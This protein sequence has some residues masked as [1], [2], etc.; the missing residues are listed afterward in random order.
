MADFSPEEVKFNPGPLNTA[1]QPMA[2]TPGAFGVQVGQAIQNVGETADRMHKTAVQQWNQVS[3]MDAYNKYEN[4]IQDKIFKSQ[5]GLIHQNFG[6]DA[7]GAVEK[8]Q[9]YLK[10]QSSKIN[11]NLYNEQ[12]KFMFQRMTQERNLQLQQHLN[13]YADRQ[14]NNY[15]AET[16]QA[17]TK[18]AAQNAVQA[19][20]GIASSTDPKYS[21]PNARAGAFNKAAKEQLDLGIAAIKD[22]FKHANPTAPDT[23]V[24][25]TEKIAAYQSA[26]TYG[27]ITSLG[28]QGKDLDAERYY[29]DHKSELVGEEAVHAARQVETGSRIGEA[30]TIINGLRQDDK[31]QERSNADIEKDILSNP[32]VQ[33]DPRLQEAVYRQFNM[34]ARRRDIIHTDEQNQYGNVLYNAITDPATRGDLNTIQAQHPHEWEMLDGKSKE[35]FIELSEKIQKNMLPKD[36]SPAF[37]NFMQ[38]AHS[39]EYIDSI[40]QTGSQAAM[41]ANPQELVNAGLITPSDAEKMYKEQDRI[42]GNQAAVAATT[43]TANDRAAVSPLLINA[44]LNPKEFTIKAGQK[45][46][47][48]SPS[49]TAVLHYIETGKKAYLENHPNAKGIPADELRKLASEAVT[50]VSIAKPAEGF[51]NSINPLAGKTITEHKKVGEVFEN[52]IR[53]ISQADPVILQKVKDTLQSKGI[54]NPSDDDLINGYNAYG[55]AEDVSKQNPLRAKGSGKTTKEPEVVPS[56]P[57]PMARED[58]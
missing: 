16:T 37:I 33:E 18:N 41:G 56:W 19:V 53:T 10:E 58:Q 29:N 13:D 43:L 11:D 4:A 55:L 51:W 49:T 5:T 44:G 40:G 46:P 3:A 31:G 47:T 50:D 34:L 45:I 8:T 7:I 28:A 24:R 39:P 27:I 20:N 14:I 17:F 35:H 1:P 30:I 36:G 32:H 23:D 57:P 15:D 21:E 42:Q 6:K 22:N 52:S 12:Q 25:L 26:A 2:A 38:L 54:Q 9:A 48:L